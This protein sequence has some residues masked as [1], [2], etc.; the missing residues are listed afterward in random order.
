MWVWI[1][2]GL[3]SFLALSL[4]VGFTLA[5]VLGTIGRQV[6]E[7]YEI[8]DWATLPPTRASKVVKEQQVGRAGTRRSVEVALRTFFVEPCAIG[9]DSSSP[10]LA[11]WSVATGLPSVGDPD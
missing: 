9:H 11:S 2:I 4:L 3:G 10:L 6:S 8:E 7:L 5:R 1:V